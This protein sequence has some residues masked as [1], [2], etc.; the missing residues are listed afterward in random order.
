MYWYYRYQKRDLNMSHIWLHYFCLIAE[1]TFANLNLFNYIIFMN[2]SHSTVSLCQR[3]IK[4][5]LRASFLIYIS[6]MNCFD[7]RNLLQ[8]ERRPLFG[9]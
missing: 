6:S 7:L 5:L 9:V 4:D 1:Q 3:L 8:M 2:V